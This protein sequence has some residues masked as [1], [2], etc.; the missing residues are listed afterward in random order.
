MTNSEKILFIRKNITEYCIGLFDQTGVDAGLGVLIIDAV[1]SDV[2]NAAL[3]KM[4]LYKP[5]ETTKQ[6]ELEEGESA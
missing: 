2:Y 3:S 5:Q 1:R 4:M 6:E